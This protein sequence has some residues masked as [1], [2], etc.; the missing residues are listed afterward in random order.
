MPDAAP[1]PSFRWALRTH[2]GPGPQPAWEVVQGDP[3]ISIRLGCGPDTVLKVELDHRRLT[4]TSAAAPDAA[5]RAPLHYFRW[6]DATVKP[7]PAAADELAFQAGD[8]YVALTPGARRLADGAAVARF[9]H[10]RD[11]FNAGRLAEA[12]IGHLVELGGPR[13]AVEDITVLV[14]EA[15]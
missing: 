11:Y 8:A 4:L 1:R 5:G 15:R 14:V 2:L 13:A 7:L 6:A 10:L 12:V 9:I 3:P